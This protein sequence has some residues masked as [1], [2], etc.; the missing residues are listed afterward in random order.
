MSNTMGI[1][2]LMHC[3]ALQ[4][5]QVSLVKERDRPLG[6]AQKPHQD[7]ITPPPMASSLPLT[8]HILSSFALDSSFR[9]FLIFSSSR[10]VLTERVW[11]ASRSITRPNLLI[12]SSRTVSSISE[13]DS[14]GLS[15]RNSSE[16]NEQS[17]R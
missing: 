15:L 13:K 1:H 16:P 8:S 17:R 10:V 2:T 3:L 5:R 6:A 14:H 9:S 4:D 11:R 12:I 7:F